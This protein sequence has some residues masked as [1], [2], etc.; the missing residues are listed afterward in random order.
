MPRQG[1]GAETGRRGTGRREDVKRE[2]VKREELLLFT[3]HVF[4]FHDFTFHDFTPAHRSPSPAWFA[5]LP[6]LPSS[7]PDLWP[8]AP[9]ACAPSDPGSAGSCGT[10]C[11]PAACRRH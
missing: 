7:P 5:A 10:S 4:T 8:F 6:P 3:F 1:A 9:R 11:G 2:D